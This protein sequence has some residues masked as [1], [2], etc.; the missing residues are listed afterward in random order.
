MAVRRTVSSPLHHPVLG[1]S[2]LRSQVK[3]FNLLASLSPWPPDNIP[4]KAYPMHTVASLQVQYVA[5]KFSWHVFRI[6]LWPIQKDYNP[7]L[8]IFDL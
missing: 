8:E 6:R 2:C 4:E 7:F 3:I 5:L 1:M